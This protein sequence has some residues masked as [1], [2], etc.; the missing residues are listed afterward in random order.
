MERSEDNKDV[1]TER[2]L[3]ML[4]SMITSTFELKVPEET[5]KT[6]LTSFNTKN[7]LNQILDEES[8]K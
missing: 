8:T 3:S 4:K 1:S 6:E 7:E 5:F 2:V